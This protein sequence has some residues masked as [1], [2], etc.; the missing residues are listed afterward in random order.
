[1]EVNNVP[2]ISPWMIYAIDTIDSLKEFFKLVT[3]L[4]TFV[5]AIMVL[6]SLD[7]YDGTQK[8]GKRMKQLAMFILMCFTVMC[9][10]P[11]STTLTK[12]VIAKNVTY[13]RVD[14]AK[15]VVEQIYNDILDVV[16]QNK[17]T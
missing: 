3:I 4:S 13:E 14:T 2:I 10:V 6:I 16:K 1:M 12:M 5:L 15:D 11:S 8:Y 17:H 7:D 9:V